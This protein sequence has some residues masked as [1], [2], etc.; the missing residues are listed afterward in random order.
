MFQNCK[1][2]SLKTLEN[3]HVN[4]SKQQKTWPLKLEL[5]KYLYKPSR[6]LYFPMNLSVA[7]DGHFDS[8]LKA[9]EFIKGHCMY[10]YGKFNRKLARQYL[11]ECSVLDPYCNIYIFQ[12][13]VAKKEFEVNFKKANAAK[14]I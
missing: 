14:D 9:L 1:E 8:L 2:K 6:E 12:E 3:V 11:K 7:N 4:E 13:N 10:H 5:P